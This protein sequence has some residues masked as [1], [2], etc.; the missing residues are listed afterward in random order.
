[1]AGQAQNDLG[2][3]LWRAAGPAMQFLHRFISTSLAS[4]R[5]DGETR[6][7]TKGD[8]LISEMR[9]TL[10]L[11]SRL[12]A[13]RGPSNGGLLLPSI[14]LQHARSAMN[15]AWRVLAALATAGSE[16]DSLLTWQAVLADVKKFVWHSTAVFGSEFTLI[17]RAESWLIDA[18]GPRTECSTI[19][20]RLSALRDLLYPTDPAELGNPDA[21]EAYGLREVDAVELSALEGT[22]PRPR[23]PSPPNVLPLAKE[24]ADNEGNPQPDLWVQA[25]IRRMAQDE[26]LQCT[27]TQAD[28]FMSHI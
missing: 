19:G 17:I 9:A 4:R 25:Q 27:S 5:P 2:K 7:F 6:S 13:E 15:A 16:R 3:A 22:S 24:P 12:Q 8:G 28:Y 23:A 18:N 10:S 11:I 14:L 21:Y 20:D 26:N 1:M